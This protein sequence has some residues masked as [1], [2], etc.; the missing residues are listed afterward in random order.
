M[1]PTINRLTLSLGFAMGLGLAFVPQGCGG[2]Q[3]PVA[4]IPE[5]VA[6]PIRGCAFEHTHHV[7][8]ADHIVKYDVTLDSNGEVDTI[9]LMDSTVGDEELEQCIAASIRSLTQYDL[10]R[11]RSENFDRELAPPESRNLLGNPAVPLAACLASPP[12]LL[13]LAM[14]MGASVITVQLMVHAAT[15]KP[16]TTTTAPP[17]PIPIAVPRRWPGQTCEDAE[18]DRLEAEKDKICKPP[19]GFATDCPKNP[20]KKKEY[21]KI[22]CSLILLAIQQRQA[23]KAAR[24][25]VQNKCFGGNPNPGHKTAID[26]EQNAIDN[27]EAFKL[28]NCAKDHPMAGK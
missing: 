7:R 26:Q 22:P 23:C 5:H 3:H 13:S 17:I 18:L 28:I 20:L 9:A 24:W 2:V 6:A 27:C 12:C 14:V 15:V 16:T 11:H 4:E 21:A 1:V 19:E 10:L 8:D 25:L